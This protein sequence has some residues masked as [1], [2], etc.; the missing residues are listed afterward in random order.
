MLEPRHKENVQ[1]VLRVVQTYVRRPAGVKPPEASVCVCVCVCVCMCV[2]HTA[3]PQ[4]ELLHTQLKGT[5]RCFHVRHVSPAGRSDS[6]LNKSTD[7]T[8]ESLF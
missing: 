6:S 4:H 7:L 5:D 8:T 2:R 1:F 3:A